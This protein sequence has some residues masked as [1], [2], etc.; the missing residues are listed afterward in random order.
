MTQSSV[1]A[2]LK[3]KRSVES[4]INLS[5]FYISR[6]AN[7]YYLDVA[8]TIFNIQLRLTKLVYDF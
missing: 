5:I 4:E 1:F 6:N 8:D 2:T 3:I 7:I